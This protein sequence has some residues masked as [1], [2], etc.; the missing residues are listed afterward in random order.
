MLP[1][2]AIKKKKKSQGHKFSVFF[3]KGLNSFQNTKY[4]DFTCHLMAKNIRLSLNETDDSTDK[5]DSNVSKSSLQRKLSN[6]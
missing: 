3:S 1:M 4:K 2:S 6:H 5:T